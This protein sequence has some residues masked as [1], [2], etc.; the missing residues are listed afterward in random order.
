M[1]SGFV[2]GYDA[3]V[4]HAV[5]HGYRILV[6]SR[7]Y[8]LVTGITGIDDALDLG[9]H[10]RTQA[11]IVLASFFRLTGAFPGLFNVC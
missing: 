2:L 6:G 9:T 3:L 1:T 7:R 8:R 11:H 4:D 5:D 10:Q